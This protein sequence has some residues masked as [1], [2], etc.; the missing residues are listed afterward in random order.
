MLK[1]YFVKE[2]SFTKECDCSEDVF[3]TKKENGYMLLTIPK[4]KFLGFKNY[5][6]LGLSY[7]AWWKSVGHKLQNLMFPFEWLD[8]YKKLSHVGP[9]VYEDFYRSLKTTIVQDE[10]KQFLKKFKRNDCITMGDWL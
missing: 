3:A 5:I 10:Y 4:F 2:I 9:V 8:S 6:G 1:K 7:D